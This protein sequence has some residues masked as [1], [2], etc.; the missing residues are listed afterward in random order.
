IYRCFSAYAGYRDEFYDERLAVLFIDPD[1]S[2][3]VLVPH[4]G[5]CASCSDLS[6]IRFDQ[7]LQCAATPLVSLL[8]ATSNNNPCC[9]GPFRSNEERINYYVLQDSEVKLAASVLR[10]REESEHDDLNGDMT[11]IYDAKI[12]EH[13][14]RDG[15]VTHIGSRYSRSENGE[16]RQT[17]EL[18]YVWNQEKKEFDWIEK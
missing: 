5:N 9:D 12:S 17:G 3:L 2:S 11:T 7:V 15:N 8:I 6:H 4:A 14:D 13:R 16:L 18:T 10:H 1:K